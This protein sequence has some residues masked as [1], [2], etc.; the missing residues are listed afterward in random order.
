M[1][2]VQSTSPNRSR[3]AV[4]RAEAEPIATQRERLVAALQQCAGAATRCA[5][6][7]E[8]SLDDAECVDACR[9][10][11]TLCGAA[12]ELLA[13]RSSTEAWLL[14][15]AL[16]A[17]DDCAQACG[18]HAGA[19]FRSCENA[20]DTVHQTASHIADVSAA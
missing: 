17:S 7:A 12:A 6:S 16:M 18:R 4:S 1:R 14:V 15:M 20:C 11:A 13:R 2:Q 10:A 3:R 5:A 8:G 9:D 19:A